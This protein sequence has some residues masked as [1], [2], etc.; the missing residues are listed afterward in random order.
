RAAVPRARSRRSFLYDS[1]SLITPA[2]ARIARFA[3]GWWSNVQAG[4]EFLGATRKRRL[5]N[6]R[7]G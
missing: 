2:F 7:N 6:G 5:S 3:F 4:G 1:L